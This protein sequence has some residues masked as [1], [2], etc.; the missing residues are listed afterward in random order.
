M[1]DVPPPL[2]HI[3]SMI[4]PQTTADSAFNAIR[5]IYQRDDYISRASVQDI[6]GLMPLPPLEQAQVLERVRLAG[7]F[8]APQR[9]LIPPEEP[10]RRSKSM[11]DTHE[12]Q[13]ASVKV[14]PTFVNVV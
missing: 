2:L 3:P 10:Q 4:A 14:R 12:E 1:S 7:L 5:S 13:K 11:G 9:F 8:V 6:L